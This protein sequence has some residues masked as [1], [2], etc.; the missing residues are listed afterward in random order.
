MATIKCNMCGGLVELPEN[1]RSAIC[2]HC[3]S[4]VTPIGGGHREP[5]HSRVGDPDGD[6]KF[7][8]TVQCKMCGAPLTLPENARS[9]TCEYCGSPV[10]FPRIT[11]EAQERLYARAEHFRRLNDYD[12][13]RRVAY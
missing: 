2:E 8:P 6:G 5:L 12:K 9:G 7:A 10:T 11:T 13:A 4:T 1:A 3:G